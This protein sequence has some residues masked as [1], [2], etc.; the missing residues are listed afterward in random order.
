[1]SEKII[2]MEEKVNPIR[3]TDNET[4]NVYELDFDR[5]SID[6]AERR[7]FKIREVQDYP[8][9]LVPEMFYYAFRKNH[10]NVSRQKT[11]AIF[12]ELGGLTPAM[13]DR[14]I[15]LYNQGALSHIIR[16]DE[17]EVKNSR[18]TVEL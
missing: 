13:L 18:M 12:D 6:F 7:G 9:S 8:V 16:D 11:D 5:A 14:L 1:M 2:E 10:K 17:G 4:G 15:A 3:L